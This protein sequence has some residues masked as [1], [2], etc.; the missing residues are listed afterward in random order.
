MPP[1]LSQRLFP[2]AWLGLCALA[3]VFLAQYSVT[4]SLK[5]AFT[6]LP[7]IKLLAN[8]LF[9]WGPLI[10]LSWVVGAR[11]ATV[12]ALGFTGVV[13]VA[14]MLK[15]TH[16]N[17]P[18]LLYDFQKIGTLPIV[19]KYVGWK[20]VLAIVFFVGAAIYLLFG[21]RKRPAR[22]VYEPSPKRRPARVWVT[23]GVLALFTT[24]VL[25]ALGKCALL[26]KPLYSAGDQLFNSLEN[27]YFVAQ[28]QLLPHLRPVVPS[29][30]SKESV[31][32]ILAPYSPP[33]A[34]VASPS[35]V[36]VLLESFR[37]FERDGLPTSRPAV[38]TLDALRKKVKAP[39]FFSPAFGG[40]TALVEF[41]VLSAL[42]IAFLPTGS[43]P[44]SQHIT[45]PV[46]TLPSVLK[47]AGYA[48]LAIHNSDATFWARKQ[49]YG[50]MG[51]D[52]FYAIEDL[53]ADYGERGEK[54]SA[55][56][57]KSL[58][59]LASAT[60]PQFQFLINFETHGPYNRR[61]SSESWVGEAIAEPKRSR[62]NA[63]FDK[64]HQLDTDLHQY[65][66]GLSKLPHP[67]IVVLFSD[68]QPSVALD[69][70]P[71]TDR[72][73]LNRTEV[74]FWNWPQITLPAQQTDL[75]CL[76]PWILDAAG[77]GIP[78]YFQF[79]RDFCRKHPLIHRV[80]AGNTD[81]E[82]YRMLNHDRLAGEKYSL[83]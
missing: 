80:Q 21:G 52:R 64:L 72:E 3:C 4:F 79:T 56:F 36:L 13:A 25:E 67:P 44:Y 26:P 78:R 9:V 7:D 62:L 27:G 16:L 46:P 61:L 50:P 24:L 14:N 22:Y 77:Q 69:A 65:F 28:A 19:V 34:A 42:R 8:L 10:A 49:A 12:L 47:E 6:S 58:E 68:H 38:P 37:D 83:R 1:K 51:I 20:E 53:V 82:N 2:P 55:V 75:A 15:I 29:N 17:S 71:V 39:E 40:A 74:F 48:T 66:E 33:T 70:G 11:A 60:Q 57:Q 59:L 18:F 23:F 45:G 41:E 81:F 32:K 73:L 5:G 30:Y 35:V 43:L 63:Y 76:A 54:D 31:E